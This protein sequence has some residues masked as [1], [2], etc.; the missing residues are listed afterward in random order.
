LKLILGS[1][2]SKRWVLEGDIS[3]FFDTLSH[4]WIMDNIPIDK[5]ILMEFLK[6]GYKEDNNLFETEIGVPQGNL[7]SPIIASMALDGLQASLEPKFRVARYADDF[8]VV[9]KSK[10]ELQDV[11]TPI[12]DKFLAERGLKLNLD[13]T[14]ITEISEGFNFLG[15]YF[16]EYPDS[17][18]VK[19]SKQGIF[20]V[21]PMPS[22]VKG[23]LIRIKEI[24]RDSKK[25]ST[26]L[27][28]TKLN[29]ILRG[30]AEYYRC[31]TSTRLFSYVGWRV[32]LLL[33]SMLR[34]K[35][36]GIPHRTLARSKFMKVEGNNWVL[37]G[38]DTKGNKVTLYQMGW[39]TITR[40]HLLKPLNPFLVENAEYFENLRSKGLKHSVDLNKQQRA[41]A[42]K[43]KGS[44]PV[45][46]DSLIGNESL[47]VHH[48]IPRKD[49]GTNAL[50]NLRLLH[51][52]CHKLVTHTKDPRIL[53]G[54]R[55]RGVI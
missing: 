44:C 40:H 34:K 23:L 50:Y 14:L 52:E 55:G 17:N 10:E 45:C 41:L 29:P 8:V 47:E 43:Q 48:V 39:T 2:T 38:E 7:I 22:K 4:D 21:K 46:L 37:F 12:I 9:G 24:I 28:I 1:P 18:R 53:A 32:W 6:A 15:F 51:K 11:A 5:R 3:K 33:W 19:G 26:A 30:W 49:N 20:L 36:R 54:R 31:V 27:L 25:H 42:I 16:K 35:H 13:K